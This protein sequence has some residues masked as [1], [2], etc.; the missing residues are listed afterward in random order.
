MLLG[1][2]GLFPGRNSDILAKR[3]GLVCEQLDAGV[4]AGVRL[5]PREP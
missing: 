1:R 3:G 2:F 4:H 5:E